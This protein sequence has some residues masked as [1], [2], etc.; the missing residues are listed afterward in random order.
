MTHS[1]FVINPL[2]ILFMKGMSYTDS[3]SSCVSCSMNGIFTKH[4]LQIIDSNRSEMNFTVGETVIKQGSFVSQVLF[5]KKGMV[6]M[7]LE[8]KNDRNTI[9]KLVD[10]RHFL[11]LSVLGNPDQ[12]PFSLKAVTECSIC[13][14]KKEIIYDII[15]RNEKAYDFVFSWYA[16]DYIQM[17]NKMATISTRNNH[18]KVATTLLN[19]SNGQFSID[20]L[21][22][23]SRKDL[24]ELSSTSKESTNKILQQLN[25]DGIISIKKDKIDIKRRDLLEHL[26]TVG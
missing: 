19:L 20:A 26:S 8:G 13:F 22:N 12:Y 4:D 10:D 9:V 18:G 6:K 16:N 25:H 14:I 3:C 1:G 24:A 5:L 15:K 2:Y 23:I 7:V 21:N 17:Y 11:A